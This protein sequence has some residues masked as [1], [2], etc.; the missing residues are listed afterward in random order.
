MEE[1]ESLYPRAYIPYNQNMREW[2]LRAGDPLSLTLSADARLS[3]TDYC[4][5]QIWQLS[6]DGGE[7]PALALQTT[8]G[9]RARSLR[10]WPR[11]AE[12]GIRIND[13][14]TFATS[15]SIH[16]FYPNYVLVSFSPFQNLEVSAEFWVP[17]SQAAAGRLH[18]TN[19]G[20]IKRQ[21]QL[22][23]AAVLMVSGEGER[24]G[25]AEFDNVSVLAGR[26]GNLAPVLFMTGGAL[27]STASYPALTQTLD[28]DP[29]DACTLTWT[30]AA[31]SDKR[32]SFDLA[33]EIAGR[34]WEAELARIELLNSGNVEIYTGEPDWDAAFSLSQKVAYGLFLQ[35]TQHLDF[36]SFVLTRQP[37]QGYS[38]RGDGLDYNY[39]WNGQT[40]LDTYFICS[41][42]LPAAADLAQGLL[43]NFLQTYSEDGFIDWKP[44]LGGQRSQLLATPLLS[45]L[46]WR[47]FQS[48][49]DL[50]FLRAVYPP[51]QEFLRTWFTP[52]HDRD[53]DGVPEWDHALQ[54]NF[55]EHPLFSP[56][57]DW[58]QGAEISTAESPG[59]CA[60]LYSECQALIRM[61]RLLEA[62]EAIPGL[63]ALADNLR[64]AVEIS[65]E[66]SL[67]IYRYWDRDTH[68]CTRG[69]VLG[70]RLGAG[71]IVLDRQFDHP[72][73]LLLRLRA[74]GEKTRP[75][76]VYIHGIT[77]N[78]QH[79]IEP[80]PFHRWQWHLTNATATGERIYT[81]VER[82]LIEGLEE[83]DLFIAS[84]VGY[85]GHDHSLL[86]PLWAGI[87][88]KE[89]AM[90]LVKNTISNPNRFWRLYGIPTTPELSPDMAN[91]AV[92]S[93]HVNMPWNL[94]IGEGLLAYGFVEEASE[95]VTRLMKAIVQTLKQ[96]GSFRKYYHTESGYGIG[97]P[98]S[99][100]GLA[101]VS[102]FL[103]CLGVSLLSPKKVF[104]QGINPFPWPVTVKYRGLTV[105]RQLEKTTVI[106][107]NG[108]TITVNDPSPC[109][110]TL[111]SAPR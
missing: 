63:E 5:D 18:I 97:D 81:Y 9:L 76:R 7:P 82:I 69:E 38:I 71:E 68:Y 74:V 19:Q 106:F 33:R 25:L 35:A 37:D 105:L 30:L 40:P 79:I 22:E 110:V 36:P 86:L 10:L 58:S 42:L 77:Q 60:L 44:G 26:T 108:E 84:N 93:T 48:T 6:L 28:L 72:I 90:A 67:S 29:Q 111:E 32:A 16:R 13:P 102:L 39:S 12:E 98:N 99:L 64:T 96:D 34:N 87:P 2:N 15:P 85:T 21:I 4:N 78:G 27:S 31:L 41:L 43:R 70:Q 47:I 52:N 59:L 11:F 104:L 92:F 88:A 75:I 107:P 100:D 55:D 66:P 80:I 53:G 95:L 1:A 91:N 49:G 61:A 8:F 50:S 65:W 3:P 103:D 54:A 101:P 20:S 62:P 14:D 89:R 57:L 51:L 94:L 109:I 46:A 17:L 24:M 56:W 83:S 23:W 45:N 73:R